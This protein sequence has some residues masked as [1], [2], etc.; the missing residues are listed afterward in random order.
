MR[1][2]VA[3]TLFCAGCAPPEF[4][5]VSFD[6]ADVFVQQPPSE[7]DLLVV[8]DDSVSLQPFHE[9]IGAAF[10][11]FVG[12]F[13]ALGIDY[14]L[15]VVTT[16]VLP[17]ATAQSSGCSQA[18][19]D[20]VPSPGHLVDGV[21]ITP[22]VDDAAAMFTELTAVGGCG[23]GLEMGL[24]AAL[25]A[26]TGPAA[27]TTNRGFLRAGAPLALVFVS[28]ED[29]VSPRSV[30]DYLG[31]F[32]TAKG[33]STRDAYRVSA[34]VATDPASCP[35]DQ[36]ALA[37]V[38]SR[39]LAAAEQTGGVV[40]DICS[41]DF[42]P[43]AA[44]ISQ[45]SA[46]LLEQFVLTKEPDPM[47]IE[48]EQDGVELPRCDGTWTFDRDDLDRPVVR[49]LLVPPPPDSRISVRYLLGS[50]DPAD[51]CAGDAP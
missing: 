50:G 4:S 32:Q 13:D 18:E 39:Y 26:L 16:S 44:R 8:L 34:I 31:A 46:A 43:A 45:L 11:D 19:I 25:L 41:D 12:P 28:D 7:L 29:D 37:T 21:W 5:V 23:A 49:F 42:A 30:G 35:E 20:A 51:F 48:V 17:A 38:G 2:V 24:E 47:T 36:A 9:R 14:H 15:G 6:W 1:P 3:M 33:A 10:A 40:A 22:E 27:S